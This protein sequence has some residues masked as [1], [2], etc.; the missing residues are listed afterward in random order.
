MRLNTY[1]APNKNNVKEIK[2]EIVKSNTANLFELRSLSNEKEQVMKNNSLPINIENI[3]KQQNLNTSEFLKI[4]F[5]TSTQ[6]KN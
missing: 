6:G 1:T 2:P 5:R 3:K 4:P